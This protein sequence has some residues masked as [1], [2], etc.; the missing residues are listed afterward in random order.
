MEK[1]FTVIITIIS[2]V[3]LLAGPQAGYSQQTGSI[4]GTVKAAETGKAI[5]GANLF[6]KGTND[7]AAT[8]AGGTFEITNVPVGSYQVR[9]SYVGY[10]TSIKTVHVHTGQT[11]RLHITLSITSARL[12]EL[13]VT[14]R[15]ANLIGIAGSAS[16]GDISQAQLTKR[17]MIRTGDI[18]ET[19]P[20]LIISQHSGEGKA[21]QF[22]LRG[23]NL[24]HGT[25]FAGFLEGMPLNL[26][27]PTD[28]DI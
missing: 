25:D 16:Q 13:V 6:L 17:P 27:T 15:A 18:M 12:N 1:H 19:I 24:D 3:L 2:G 21:N 7:G 23:F 10:N 28:R 20:G 4:K 9:A 11:T 22:Y 14:G 8:S 5:E 26:R